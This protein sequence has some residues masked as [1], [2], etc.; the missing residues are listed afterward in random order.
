LHHRRP[1]RQFQDNGTIKDARANLLRSE[2]LADPPHFT[3]QAAIS[4]NLISGD[5]L[6]NLNLNPYPIA[7][8]DSSG[9]W[10]SPASFRLSRFK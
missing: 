8:G 7:S 2:S 5:T 3:G 1:A 10:R 4:A 9:V 6:P